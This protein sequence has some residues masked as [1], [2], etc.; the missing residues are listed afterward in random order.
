MEYPPNF[1]PIIY[2]E[3]DNEIFH[4]NDNEAYEHYLQFGLSAGKICNKIICKNDLL[5]YKSC[6][7]GYYD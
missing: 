2:R 3:Y 4:L 7:D 1:D 5:N 6:E